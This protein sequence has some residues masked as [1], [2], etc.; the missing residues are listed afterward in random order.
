MR[1]RCLFWGGGV[2]R[3]IRAS[4]ALGTPRLDTAEV[5]RTAGSFAL[6]AAVLVTAA[7][8]GCLLCLMKGEGG[9]LADAVGNLSAPYVVVA[10]VAGL[11][12]RRW[13][14]A[15]LAGVAA[16]EATVGGF[17]GTWATYFGHE[18]SQSAL[19]QWGGAGICSGAVFGAIGW[20]A[21]SRRGLRYVIPGL[22]LLEPVATEGVAPLLARFGFG[23]GWGVVD[24][25]SLFAFGVEIAVGIAVFLVIRRHVRSLR[26]REGTAASASALQAAPGIWGSRRLRD[27]GQGTRSH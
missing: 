23:N 2:A 24:L 15:A 21:R 16:T 7:V 22:L 19:L 26:R 9:G 27:E 11:V 1:C 8:L 6:L 13:W 12:V 10:V 18:V 14:L 20:A 5:S 3:L 25:T 4:V 17:Y